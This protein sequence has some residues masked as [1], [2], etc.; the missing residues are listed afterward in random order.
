MGREYENDE[1]REAKNLRLVGLTRVY[2]TTPS[3]IG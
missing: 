1:E 2:T 3:H